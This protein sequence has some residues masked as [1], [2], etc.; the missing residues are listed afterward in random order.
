MDRGD[1]G[2]RG[3]RG[4]R[5]DSWGGCQQKIF[6]NYCKFLCTSAYSSAHWPTFDV[7]AISTDKKT[8]IF[9]SDCNSFKYTINTLL[10][11][12]N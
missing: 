7:H 1:W 8:A 10:L 11:Y 3:G 2:G 9:T 4:D 12:F 5:G 6:N